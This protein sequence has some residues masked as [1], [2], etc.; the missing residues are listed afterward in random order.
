MAGRAELGDL[1]EAAHATLDGEMCFPAERS[2]AFGP[3]GLTTGALAVPLRIFTD[4][5]VLFFNLVQWGLL[6]VSAWILYWLV[7]DWTGAAPAGIVAG[8]IFA[9]HYIKS[10]D[11]VHLYVRDT[12]WTLLALLFARRLFEHGRWRD[13]AGLRSR[14]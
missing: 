1:A 11:V 8:T 2:L 4:D 9:F 5:P 3:S 7:V 10:G 12:V 6:L 14:R 13:A